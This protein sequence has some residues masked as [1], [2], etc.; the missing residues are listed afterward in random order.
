MKCDSC[1]GSG[2]NTR[3]ETCFFCGGSGECCDRCGEAMTLDECDMGMCQ[4]CADEETA[5]NGN[6]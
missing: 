5:E 6:K 2:E 4:A 1:K 3:G